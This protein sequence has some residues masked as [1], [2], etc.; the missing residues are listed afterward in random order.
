[1]KRQL[2]LDVVLVAD[3]SEVK[4]NKK[5]RHFKYVSAKKKLYSSLTKRLITGLSNKTCPK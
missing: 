3:D 4:M 1:M 2:G 5:E